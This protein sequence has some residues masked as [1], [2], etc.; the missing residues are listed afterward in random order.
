[1]SF[2]PPASDKIWT[3]IGLMS[4]TSLDGID[5]AILQT[6]GQNIVTPGLHVTVPYSDARRAQIR[7]ILGRTNAAEAEIAIIADALTQDHAAAISLLLQKAALK[8]EDIDLIGFHGQTIFHDPKNG[9]TRQIGTPAMLARQFAVPVVA[10]FRIADVRAGGQGA[11]LIPFYHAALAR[12][13]HC[14]TPVAF[15][16]LGG[17]GNVTWVGAG[18]NDLVA[19]DTGPANALID[20]AV[21]QATGR[22]QDDGGMLASQGH[23]HTDIVQKWLAHPYFAAPPPKSLDRDAFKVDV[24]HLP[25]AD[26]IATLTAFTV[27]SV[28]AAFDHFPAPVRQLYVCGGGRHN[29]TIMAGLAAGLKDVHVAPVEALGFDGDALEAHGFAYLAVRSR[30]RLPLSLPTTTGVSRP[31]TGGCVTV[32]PGAACQDAAGGL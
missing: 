31:L 30:L 26:R 29:A 6:D 22:R 1:M 15:L 5:A 7:S 11:P 9:I 17:V 19:F 13:A 24:A 12:T 27:Q 28:I 16:N 4:G 18:P 25:L 10:D 20:D 32:P 2:I 8:A 3:A 14:Q 21:L 23:V